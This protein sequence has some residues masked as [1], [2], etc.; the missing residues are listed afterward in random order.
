[1]AV[2]RPIANDMGA[3]GRIRVTKIPHLRGNRLLATYSVTVAVKMST[4]AGVT[5]PDGSCACGSSGRT[6]AKR[7]LWPRR[8]LEDRLRLRSRRTVTMVISGLPV[9]GSRQN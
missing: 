4:V 3:V 5:D 8:V 6:V 7:T 9:I 2:F 1:M